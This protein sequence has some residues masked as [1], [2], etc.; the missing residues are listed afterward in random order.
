MG[1]IF[2]GTACVPSSNISKLKRQTNLLEQ[3]HQLVEQG[4][5]DEALVS[6]SLA[7][8]QNP[9]LVDAHM[10]MG[11]IYLN[12]GDYGQ[13][14]DTYQHVAQMK[15]NH[16][17]ANYYFG[18]AQQLLGRLTDA[19]NIY[20]RTLAIKP[21]HLKANQNLATALLQQGRAIEAL[22]YAE[23]AVQLKDNEQSVWIN[24]AVIYSLLREYEEA[25]EAY[26]QAAELGE[27]PT[28]VLLGLADAHLKQGNY[29][30]AS[31]VLQRLVKQSPSALAHER[32]GFAQFKLM[33]FAQALKH[34]EVALEL[35]PDDTASLNGQGVCLM[36]LYLQSGGENPQRKNDAI[37]AWRRSLQIR[38][39]QPLIKDLISRY[40]NLWEDPTQRQVNQ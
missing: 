9:C 13:A 2:L 5:T 26:R 36:T 18:L 25:V 37:N 10:G 8:Q 23:R 19:I 12:R 20:L 4:L 38:P 17:D 16:P 15:P 22:P 6:F 30:R 21:D 3:A 34:Y 32:L 40:H 35:T 33:Q 7:I 39:E 29:L 1:A 28:W 11:Q 27:M 24:L 14:S 31:V